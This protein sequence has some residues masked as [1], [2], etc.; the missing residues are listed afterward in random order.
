[1]RSARRC[2]VVRVI[3]GHIISLDCIFGFDNTR[4]LRGSVAA[5]RVVRTGIGIAIVGTAV[6]IVTPVS[7]VG[8]SIVILIIAAVV[9]TMAIL[10]IVVAVIRVVVIAV[11]WI[12]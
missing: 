5:I 6:S 9:I 12:V 7:G 11:G 4:R 1:M 2:S 10:G 3:G 8:A